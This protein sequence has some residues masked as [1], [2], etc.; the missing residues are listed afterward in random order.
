[1][2]ALYEDVVHGPSK[3]P[4]IT[5]KIT[6]EGIEFLRDQ[7]IG[8]S[9]PKQHVG[10]ANPHG[11]TGREIERMVLEFFDPVCRNGE[12]K[13]GPDVLEY[14]LDIKSHN[15]TSIA[16]NATTIGHS[17]WYDLVNK[18]YRQSDVYKKMQGHIDVWY[19]NNLCA[20]TDVNVY[21]FDYDHIQE[22]LEK[23]Y[24]ELQSIVSERGMMALFKGELLDYD[25]IYKA[26]F[27]I[28]AGPESLFLLDV[29]DSGVNFR[30][31]HKNMKHLATRAKSADAF[32]S[33]FTFL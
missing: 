16:D 20:I 13:K 29:R 8:K 9:V 18:S 25:E 22:D 28:S 30:I 31:S 6:Q 17:K 7:L 2:T 5:R 14:G 12:T 27:T 19:D 21:Y 4:K 26:D 1:M 24:D 15:A 33:N 10:I 32:S 3:Y 23:S 11:S